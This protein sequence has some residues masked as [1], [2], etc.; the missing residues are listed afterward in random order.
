MR[1]GDVTLIALRNLVSCSG[2]REL[3]MRRSA[4]EPHPR[5]REERSGAPPVIG[6]ERHLEAPERCSGDVADDRL[7]RRSEQDCV[8]ARP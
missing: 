6:D 4:R 8:D 5:F 1:L 7:G 2:T 3:W